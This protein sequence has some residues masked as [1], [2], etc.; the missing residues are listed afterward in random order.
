M[1]LEHSQ[2]RSLTQND[3]RDERVDVHQIHPEVHPEVVLDEL[4]AILMDDQPVDQ[5]VVREDQA[6]LVNQIEQAHDV[7]TIA[8]LPSDR[9]IKL[10]C[11]CEKS[12]IHDE[13]GEEEQ[14]RDDREKLEV[15]QHAAAR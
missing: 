7:Q 15:K 3:Q 12:K 1:L 6:D 14:V 2:L 10:K 9:A 8:V 4:T 13:I 11:C 5:E